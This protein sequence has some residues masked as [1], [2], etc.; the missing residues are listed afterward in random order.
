MPQGFE[1]CRKRGGR[2]RTI[3]G[4]SKQFDLQDGEYRHVCWLNNE[5]HWGEKKT[6]KDS[7]KEE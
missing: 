5:P 4:P 7:D 1:N 2:I 6:K 3:S